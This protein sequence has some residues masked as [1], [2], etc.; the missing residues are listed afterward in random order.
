MQLVK[1]KIT[2]DTVVNAQPVEKGKTLEAPA[3]D[4]RILVSLGR[5]EFASDKD[6]QTAFATA[7]AGDPTRRVRVNARGAVV[8]KISDSRTGKVEGTMSTTDAAKES[9]ESKLAS[10]KAEAAATEAGKHAKK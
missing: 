4:A 8:E 2:E 5:A 3:D 6:E 10:A 1:I 9:A 7:E